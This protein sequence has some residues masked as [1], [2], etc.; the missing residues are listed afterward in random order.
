MII[1]I[2]G[3]SGV[4]KTTFSG[5]VKSKYP[6]FKS[7]S[8]SSLIEKYSGFI[9]YDFLTSDVVA[10]NQIKLVKAMSFLKKS[11]DSDFFIIELH[12]LIETKEGI[13]FIEE[14]VLKS[15]CLDFAF[16]LKKDAELIKE[17]R[18]RDSKKRNAASVNDIDSIQM[19]S[20]NYFL[21]IYQEKGG[22][23]IS[24]S[25]KDI[26]FFSNFIDGL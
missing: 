26:C 12:N 2:Y 5:K 17:N 13:V 14:A 24:G 19:K 25:D 8:A 16:F 1:G 3:I 15:L 7:Y 9:D 4:G 21:K 20:L 6:E 18:E 10:S 23:V 22:K 11:Q